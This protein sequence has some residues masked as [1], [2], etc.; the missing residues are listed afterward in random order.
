[1]SI[2]YVHVPYELQSWPTN[3]SF[4]IDFIQGIVML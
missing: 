4:L 2:D 1:M 3:E